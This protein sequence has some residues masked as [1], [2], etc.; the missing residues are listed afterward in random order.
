MLHTLQ[1]RPEEGALPHPVLGKLTDEQLYFVNY[2]LS[3]CGRVP[4]DKGKFSEEESHPH[5]HSPGMFRVKGVMPNVV[6]FRNAFNCPTEESVGDAIKCNSY[7]PKEHCH[8][9]I[10]DNQHEE[11]MES[12]KVKK[13][14]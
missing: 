8:V 9:W 12:L 4:L 14:D 7:A 3:Q 2:A 1:D 10:T 6:A 11:F 13:D 5:W